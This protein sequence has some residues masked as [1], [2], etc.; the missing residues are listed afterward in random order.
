MI[1]VI[2]M[3][4]ADK[5]ISDHS[6]YGRRSEL[7]GDMTCLDLWYWLISLGA[8]RHEIDKKPTEFLFV[9]YKRKSSQMKERLHWFMAKDRTWSVNQLPDLSQF[10]HPESLDKKDVQVPLRKDIDKTPRSFT[11]SLSPVLSQRHL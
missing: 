5:T 6:G 1:I 8:S 4:C 2:V 3:D 7:Y 11:V 10:A 9:L